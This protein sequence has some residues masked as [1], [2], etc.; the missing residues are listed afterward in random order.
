MN[1]L[2]PTQ[3]AKRISAC[4]NPVGPGEWCELCNDYHYTSDELQSLFA[5]PLPKQQKR[6]LNEIKA[7]WMA[8]IAER[9]NQRAAR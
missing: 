3:I 5:L 2:K 4:Q 7:W 1:T 9:Q 8:G 6:T